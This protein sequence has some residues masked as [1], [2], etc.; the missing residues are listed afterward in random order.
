MWP[1]IWYTGR[2]AGDP[3]GTLQA[4]A[5]LKAGEILY[6]AFDPSPRRWGDYTEM[7]IAP[8]GTTFWYLGEYSKNTGTTSGRWGTWI[9]SFSFTDC[10]TGG[11]T[12]TATPTSVPGSTV[13]VADLDGSST[14]SG[15]RWN[16]NVTITVHNGSEG[17]V[18]NATVSGSWSAGT[19]GTGSCVTNASGQ[20]TI[21][22]NN[23]GGGVA[24]VTFTVN[25]VTAAGQT[26]VAGS[27]H[28]PDGDSNGTAIVVPKSGSP[29]PT[30]TMTP[31]PN[32]M[33][34]GDLDGS[35]TP[36][37]GGRWNAAVT[38][39]V[40]N[41]SDASVSGATVSG[42]WSNGATGSASCVTNAG[43]QCTVSMTGLRS[44]VNSV[45]FTV[46]NVTKSGSTYNSGANH[47]PDG[48]SNGTVIV[49]AKP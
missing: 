46:S 42:S 17:P 48:D 30:P 5:Q 13:H 24:S 47:D 23:I 11:P 8:D 22:K 9:G 32:T 15:N 21:T 27:N 14:P 35:G 12:P 2:K 7:T 45:T 31:V 26:Y 36:G 6:T 40:H 19:T 18:A 4:E 41:S 1:S 33:H 44:N 3:A 39:T 49:V 25:N 38:I 29:T 34:V 28:D 20:C 43:G 37:T 16:A 10:T